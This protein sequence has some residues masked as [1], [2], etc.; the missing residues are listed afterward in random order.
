MIN[1]RASLLAAILTVNFAMHNSPKMAGGLLARTGRRY[2]SAEARVGSLTK[3]GILRLS[4]SWGGLILLKH[5]Y[6]DSFQVE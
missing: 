3:P 4:F 1:E 2:G 6:L 5:R